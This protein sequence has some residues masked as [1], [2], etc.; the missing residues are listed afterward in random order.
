MSKV[1]IEINWKKRLLIIAFASALYASLLFVF[2]WIVPAIDYTAT[3]IAFQGVFF[4]VLFGLVFPYA[5]NKLVKKVMPADGEELRLTLPEGVQIEREGFANLFKGIEAVG[6]K[7]FITKQGLMFRAHSFNIQKGSTDIRYQE[8]VSVHK[9]KTGGLV[10]NGM[11]VSTRDGK[12]YDFVLNERDEWVRKL[13]E[14]L[15]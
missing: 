8:I 7:L 4:G 2:D 6:G 3:S 5:L 14:K 10:D 15:V 12:K 1:A 11:R 13:E 9:R